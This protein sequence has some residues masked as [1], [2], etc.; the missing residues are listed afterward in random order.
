MVV[1]VVPLPNADGADAVFSGTPNADGWPKADV[2]AVPN[3][4]PFADRPVPTLEFPPDAKLRLARSN[5]C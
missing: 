3:T 2:D 1:P 4:E 5:A